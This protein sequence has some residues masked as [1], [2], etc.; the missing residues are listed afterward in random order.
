[1]ED[2]FSMDGL[3]VGHLGMTQAHYIYCALYYYDIS[4]TSDHPAL[5][6][7][8]WGPLSETITDM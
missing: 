3:G 2:D 4:S 5:D 1:M 8:D 6:P 7:R